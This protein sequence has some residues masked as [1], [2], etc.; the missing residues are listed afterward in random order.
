MKYLVFTATYNE[1]GNIQLFYEAIRREYP[2]FSILVVDDA[3]TDGTLE[4]LKNIEQ[5]DSEF[6]LI[7]RASK[8]GLG[9]AHRLAFAF[10]LN[11]EY[12]YLITLD[13]DLSHR[14][15]QI[16]RF[17]NG[18]EENDFLIGTRQ[19][20]GS[21]NY[22]GIRK[23]LSRSANFICAKLLSCGVT[24]YTSSFRLFS[25]IT[26]DYLVIRGSKRND[27]SFFIETVVKLNDANFKLS[28]VPI[29]FELRKNGASKIAKI[30]IILTLRTLLSLLFTR[31]FVEN[32][33][34]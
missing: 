2:T 12:D 20:N 30:Q 24:E 13:A 11:N 7:Q 27:Y 4:F 5:R 18:I 19:N 14:P 31:F 17:L 32:R 10:A 21:T 22:T 3:S 28:E 23:L 33:N 6:F 15:D 26:L 25:R 29:D 16:K 8:L 1:N 9:S 34:K